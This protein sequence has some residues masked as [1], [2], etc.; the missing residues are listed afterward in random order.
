MDK[1]LNKEFFKSLKTWIALISK[2]SFV[3]DEKTKIEIIVMLINKFIYI[4]TLAELSIIES[5]WLKNIWDSFERRW[6][7]KNKFTVLKKFF[8]QIENQFHEYYDENAFKRNIL[9]YVDKTKDNIATFYEN[10]QLVLGFDSS[11]NSFNK[12]RGIMQYNYQYINEDIFGKAYESCLA[13]IRHDKGVYYTPSYI[14]EFIVENTVG[15]VF[16]QL[17]AAI[18]LQLKK[19]NFEEVKRLTQKF[20][21]IKVLDP[22]C[23]SGSFLIKTFHEI[24]KKYSF[25]NQLIRKFEEDYYR[26]QGEGEIRINQIKKILG[27]E[28]EHELLRIFVRHI[29]G[30]DLDKMALNIA[31]FN[32]WLEIIKLLPFQIRFKNFQEKV[33]GILPA[34]EMNF[35][36]GNAIVGLPD[37]H[38]IEFFKQKN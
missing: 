28:N 24:Q 35:V 22:S 10:L 15:E 31:K 38:V 6:H 33:N 30:T 2:V 7:S 16:N 1:E 8:E 11:Q 32:V 17:L 3:C 18:E 26:C 25:L 27:T 5:Q 29:F 4:Q 23:G 19:E 12:F 20:V 9:D 14:V 21:S 37:T 34:L 13:E 36:H